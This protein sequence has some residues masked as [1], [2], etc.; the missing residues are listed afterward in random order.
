MNSLEY[1][2]E[3]AAIRILKAR[4]EGVLWL[5]FEHEIVDNESTPIGIVKLE[6]SAPETECFH[7]CDLV[8]HVMGA[9][10]E[11]HRQIDEAV[12]DRYALADDLEGVEEGITIRNV[13]GWAVVRS[14]DANIYARTWSNEIEVAYQQQ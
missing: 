13:A 6:R 14:S 9:A 3:H 4:V 7:R 1:M 2:V 12:G 11:I 10:D 8:L 5:P